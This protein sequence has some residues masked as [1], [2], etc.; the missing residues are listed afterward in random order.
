MYVRL[1]AMAAHLNMKCIWKE[2]FI[3]IATQN[4]VSVIIEIITEQ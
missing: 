1:V 4:T 2:A 3:K